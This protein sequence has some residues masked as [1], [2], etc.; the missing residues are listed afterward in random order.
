MQANPSRTTAQSDESIIT[1]TLEGAL[2]FG[3]LAYLGASL[4]HR[5]GLDYA[6][7]GLALGTYGLGGLV[8][9]AAVY[10]LVPLLGERRMIVVG[11]GLLGSC[12]LVLRVV[13]AWWQ[14]LPVFLLAG[15]GFYLFH[16]TLQTR[17]TELSAEARGTAVS[18]WVFMLF[19]GQGC[20]VWL[21][22]RVVDD[23]GYEAAFLAGGLGVMALGLW[24]QARIGLDA[25][26]HARTGH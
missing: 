6:L 10:R 12:Y 11:T 3:L 22:G 14:T 16:N 25:V 2:V 9:A 17:A 7:I 20:G 19:I 1:G 15:F 21:F 26:D 5:H 18:L 23:A 8:Y 24:F 13:P 4:R